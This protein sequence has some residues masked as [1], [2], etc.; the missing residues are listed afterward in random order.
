MNLLTAVTLATFVAAPVPLPNELQRAQQSLQGEWNVVEFTRQ[1]RAFDAE[2]LDGAKAVVKGNTFTLTIDRRADETTF[3]LDPTTSPATINF[4][5]ADP[6]FQGRIMAGI[7][8]L[9][10]GKLTVCCAFED[11]ERPK[12]FKS[13]ANSKTCLFVLQ[14]VK[15]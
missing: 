14:R 5:K 2:S 1:G 3:T 7:F 15:K 8:E 13:P 9:E 6:R 12:E 4:T 11:A 10:G